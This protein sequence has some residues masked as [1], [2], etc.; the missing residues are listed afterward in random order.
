HLSTLRDRT[1]PSTA[2]LAAHAPSARRRST[3]AELGGIIVG[4][5]SVVVGAQTAGNRVVAIDLHTIRR[6][7]AWDRCR[8]VTNDDMS[9]L[10]M[11]L[12]CGGV[13]RST[14]S[15][16]NVQGQHGT[17]CTFSS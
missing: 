17:H 14:E 2:A 5:G 9:R 6:G 16:Q 7:V 10:A 4:R 3:A 13:R 12:R 11:M 1:R 8:A 15:D